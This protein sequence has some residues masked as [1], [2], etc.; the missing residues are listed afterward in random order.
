[1]VDAPLSE[2]TPIAD[3]LQVAMDRSDKI[4]V[5]AAVELRSAID[6]LY[7]GQASATVSALLAAR[8]E[9]SRPQS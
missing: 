4:P 6:L 5:A 7:R 1:M 8:S 9:L 2:I 3:R